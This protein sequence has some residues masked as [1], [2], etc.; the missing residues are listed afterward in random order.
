MKNNNIEEIKMYIAPYHIFLT[1]NMIK[2]GCQEH[3]VDSWVNFS[4]EEIAEMD[5]GAQEWWLNHSVE[6][7]SAYYYA[8]IEKSMQIALIKHEENTDKYFHF[9]ITKKSEND[10]YYCNT[11]LNN[12]SENNTLSDGIAVDYKEIEKQNSVATRLA[13]RNTEDTDNDRKSVALYIENLKRSHTEKFVIGGEYIKVEIE[14]YDDCFTAKV[15]ENNLQKHAIFFQNKR[16]YD[17]NLYS[18]EFFRNNVSDKHLKIDSN[19]DILAVIRKCEI[20]KKHLDNFKSLVKALNSTDFPAIL[21]LSEDKKTYRS[22]NL[23][24]ASKD[25]ML[26]SI[27]RFINLNKKINEMYLNNEYEYSKILEQI[28]NNIS[29][30][31]FYEYYNDKFIV[32]KNND[33]VES[34]EEP[35]QLAKFLW[36]MQKEI[37]N[38]INEYLKNDFRKN[39]KST[40]TYPEI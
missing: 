23:I 20:E 15:I 1:E 9:L 39:L 10:K 16:L 32:L 30:L 11:Y 12:D 34:L 8:F 21:E 35:Q 28:E 40:Y 38:I 13:Y 14:E 26:L 24:Q 22:N 29:D 31:L 17:I 18:S 4:D 33:K 27:N 25:K 3:T 2:I 36:N 6:I 19:N 37:T 7:I 5:E